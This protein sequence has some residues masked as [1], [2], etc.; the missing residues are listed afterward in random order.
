MAGRTT[1]VIA[2]RLDTVIKADNIIVLKKG[3][4][5]R[6]RGGMEGGQRKRKVRHTYDTHNSPPLTRTCPSPLLLLPLQVVEEG[7][8]ADLMA[9]SAAG[10]YRTLMATQQVRNEGERERE[11]RE[12]GKEG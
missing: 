6:E 1:L 5:R 9:P 2:H 11:G 7:K 3:K 10:H 8:H 12:A 4:V